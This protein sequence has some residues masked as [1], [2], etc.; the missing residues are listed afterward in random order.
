M[1]D[2][3][4]LDTSPDDVALIDGGTDDAA[5]DK[6]AAP[7]AAAATAPVVKAD[8]KAADAPTDKT[9]DAG[10]GKA[11]PAATDDVVADW[12]K[13]WREKASG[14]DAKKLG[15]L[16]RY[17]SPQA[18]ADALIAAQNRISAGELKPAL[19]KDA[20]EEQIKEYRASVGIPETP[21]KYD[22]K[23]FT[24]SETDK[25][26]IDQF[27]VKAHETNQTPEQVKAGIESY[28]AIAEKMADTRRG[29]DAEVQKVSEDALRKE[30]G[31]DFR[32]N[33]NLINGFLDGAPDGLK[34]RLMMGRLSDGTPIGSDPDVLRWLL[35]VEL[36]RNPTATVV[37]GA[38][39]AMK[40]TVEDEIKQIETFM[41]KDRKAYNKD[42]KMQARYRQ[43]LEYRINSEEKSKKAA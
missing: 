2:D 37:A 28:F 1:S 22:L 43:L 21:D 33:V 42:E 39:G 24:I 32:N 6:G 7:D 30:W 34:D 41:G 13:D 5:I 40:E 29:Q 31:D 8:G 36:E 20:T 10:D 16:S 4:T 25:P 18:L 23:D 17:A 11:K 9:A 3:A 15:R 27:L 35:G 26:L 38:G 14:G 19:K 12:P